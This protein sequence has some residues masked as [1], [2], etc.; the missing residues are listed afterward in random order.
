M[1]FDFLCILWFIDN[2]SPELQNKLYTA[3][4]SG[5]HEQ[6]VQ[7]LQQLYLSDRSPNINSQSDLGKQKELEERRISTGQILGSVSVS[8]GDQVQENVPPSEVSDFN[9]SKGGDGHLVDSQ[10]GDSSVK[11]LLCGEKTPNIRREDKVAALDELCLSS[12]SDQQQ[13]NDG[14][15][16]H[17][18]SVQG[19]SQQE[20]LHLLNGRIGGRNSTLLHIASAAGHAEIVQTLLETGCDPVIKLVSCIYYLVFLSTNISLTII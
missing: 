12:Q 7:L 14:N 4:K 5:N 18:R 9:H 3:C 16:K 19:L 8:S 15:G 17:A 6:L 20:F 13:T 11:N 2:E 1:L 10:N